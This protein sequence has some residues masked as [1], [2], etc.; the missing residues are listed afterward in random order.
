MR[1]VPAGET[2]WMP[3]CRWYELV[4]LVLGLALFLGLACHQLDLPGPHYDEAI[5][6]LPAMQLLLSQ[7]VESF[8]GAA[9]HIGPLSLPLMVM[10]YIGSANTY[11]ALPFLAL[12][13]VNVTAMRLVPILFATITLVLTWALARALYGRVAGPVALFSLAAGVSFVFWSRQGIFVTNLTAMLFVAA[14]CCGWSWWRRRRR[15]DLYA[16]AF[17]CGL[18]LYTKFIF[19]WAV[20]AM[21]GAALLLGSHR[22][23]ATYREMR[24][25][26]R[27]RSAG[28][29]AGFFVAGLSPL[30]LYNVL[31][32]GTARVVATNLHSSYYGVDNLAVLANLLT[33][34]SQLLDVLRGG[35]LWYL[36]EVFENRLA[37]M[38][39][40]LVLAL[41]LSA[42]LWR[43][44]SMPGGWRRLLLPYVMIG[45]ILLESCF[46]VSALWH[47]HFA[48]L[49]PL[50]ALGLAA[51]V[52]TLAAA[53]SRRACGSAAQAASHTL[54]ASDPGTSAAG[55]V[56]R[57]PWLAL[58]GL[59]LVLA[60][61]A[62]DVR[63]DLQYHAVLTTSGGYAAH[64]D[65]SY[66]LAERLGSYAP[67][68][69]VA[70]DWGIGAQVQFLTLGRVAPR[71]IFGYDDLGAPDAGFAGRLA[72]YLADRSTVYVF[73][74]TEEEVYRGRSQ[75]FQAAV[76]AAGLRSRVLE[77]VHE[78]SGRIAYILVG[79][80]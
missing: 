5:E 7:P 36:G 10:D 37:P 6:A 46:T 12:L 76:E 35:Q 73:H 56:D 50:P 63:T 9:L 67:A 21:A 66:R 53:S 28:I 58:A 48:I 40:G 3:P 29:S 31:T 70:M 26:G 30:L 51:S 2:A 34:I 11:A 49:L 44:R 42:A 74:V 72:P 61:L 19:L 75:A 71:E 25:P 8:R 68:P 33:R 80:E 17:L 23:V 27:L 20:G 54:A 45:I 78:R 22:L 15:R 79:V 64:S 1:P 4:L 57:V 47:T 39:L 65:A 77:V 18:G 14:L 60:S 16:L 41:A 43:R 69:V 62:T 38:A 52:G 24:S 13:G 32:G 59:V 55:R